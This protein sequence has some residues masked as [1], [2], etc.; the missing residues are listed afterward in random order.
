MEQLL[1][2]GAAVLGF[3]ALGALVFLLDKIVPRTRRE[4]AAEKEEEGEDPPA[5]G[6]EDKAPAGDGAPAAAPP[7]GPTPSGP[8]LAGA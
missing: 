7:P 3:L 6:E 2:L 4:P 1:Y 5:G 8:P